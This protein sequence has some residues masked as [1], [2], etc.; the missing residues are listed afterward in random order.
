MMKK[1]V[2]G[3]SSSVMVIVDSNIIREDVENRVFMRLVPV[4]TLCDSDTFNSNSA[5]IPVAEKASPEV[6]AQYL[7]L[8][9]ALELLLD[10]IQSMKEWSNQ[11]VLDSVVSRR[12]PHRIELERQR[13]GA[14]CIGICGCMCVLLCGAVLVVMLVLNKKEFG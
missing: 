4:A 9:R 5:E 11:D 14:K 3:I 7:S 1:I 10:K 12:R 13:E 6:V 8:W 2:A